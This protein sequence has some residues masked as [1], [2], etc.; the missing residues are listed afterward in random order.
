MSTLYTY[1]DS[2]LGQLLLAARDDGQQMALSG[3]WFVGQKYEH[4]PTAAWRQVNDNPLL[5]EAAQQLAAYF[6][7]TLWRFDLPLAPIGTA[8]QQ[9][10]WQAISEVEYGDTATYGSLAQ[11][12]GGMHH[13]RAVGAATGRNPISL[14]VPCHRIL[15]SNGALTGYAG[16]LERKA[17]LLR[18]E[19]QGTETQL[20]SQATLFDSPEPLHASI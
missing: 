2:P 18:M 7:G 19:R 4:T 20:F 9:A 12:L 11:R 1:T 15:A 13:A 3:T 16:G 6:D 17:A 5:R 8:F 14:I 10:V